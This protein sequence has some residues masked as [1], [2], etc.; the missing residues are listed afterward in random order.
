LPAG[1]QIRTSDDGSVISVT[2]RKD[3]A[4]AARPEAVSSLILDL[5]P[6]QSRNDAMVGAPVSALTFTLPSGARNYSAR[7]AIEASDDLQRW[8]QLCEGT[9]SWLVN[10]S[11]ESVHKDRIEFGPSGARYAR[12]SWLEG[13]PVQFAGVTA[14]H[15]RQTAVAQQ[16]ETL[17]LKPLPG[18]FEH[19]LVYRSPIAIPVQ[20]VG[21]EFAT[22]NVVLPVLIGTYVELP[23]KNLSQRTVRDFQ[24]TIRTTFF[25]LKQNG[26]HRV[27]RDVAVEPTHLAEWV[28]RFQGPLAE[29]PRL[30]LGWNPS[31]MVFVAGGKGPYTL[32]FG[33]D[34]AEP[35]AVDIRQ[36]AP[37]FSDRELARLERATAGAVV[38]QKAEPS[39]DASASTPASAVHGRML[40]LWAL[41]LG[42]V[43]VLS[44]MAW[45]LVTQMKSEPPDSTPGP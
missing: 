11:G 31:S 28:V 35:A 32:A 42:G 13:T 45:R 2:A 40:I 24:P 19:D 43:A 30:R 18:S 26:E 29:Q 36:V 20:A 41:L 5:R 25:Q 14:D 34:K 7:I 6:P 8:E 4:A 3:A 12:V 22:E 1:L 16:M 21:L 10:S 38:Q 39:V 33:R 27:S 9:V 44:F 15:S 23:S 17:S 37:G